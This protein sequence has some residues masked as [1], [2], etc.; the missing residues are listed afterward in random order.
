[1]LMHADDLEFAQEFGKLLEEKFNCASMIISDY[2]P[3]MGY[4]SGPRALFV[5]FHPE[6]SLS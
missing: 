5:G 1:M 3:V 4:G 6:M 2:S